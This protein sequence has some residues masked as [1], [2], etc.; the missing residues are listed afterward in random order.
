MPLSMVLAHLVCYWARSGFNRV[1]ALFARTSPKAV[2][3]FLSKAKPMSKILSKA[4]ILAAS[5][6]ASETVE[7]PEWG[8]AVIVRTMTGAQRDAYE[9]TLM[10]RNDAGKLEVNTDNMRAKLLLVTLVDEQGNALFTASDLDALSGKSSGAIER[11]AVVAQKL[12]GLNKGAVEDAA[13]NS[14]SGQPENSVSGSP[15]PSA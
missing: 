5:D 10:T 4:D 14:A 11:L 6:L 13:K 9:A 1:R 3:V 7:V 2:P 8:G 12:N 15:Q